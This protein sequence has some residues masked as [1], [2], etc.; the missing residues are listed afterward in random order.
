[1]SIIDA[2]K[3]CVLTKYANFSGRA[4]RSEFWG[5]AVVNAAIYVLLLLLLLIL[6]P[7]PEL[8][9]ALPGAFA[10]AMLVPSLAAAVRR[11]HDTNKSGWL[12]LIAL[13][14]IVGSLLLLFSYLSDSDE[15]TNDYG[16][17]PK[18]GRA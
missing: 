7:G 6:D 16:A 1:M 12:L 9:L 2:W 10:L 4:R 3:T 13:V 17:S 15:K 18:Y 14:P 11:L 8:V 5:F